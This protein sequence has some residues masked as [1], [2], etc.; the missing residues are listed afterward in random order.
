M[1]H[2]TLETPVSTSLWW[3]VAVAAVFPSSGGTLD[4]SPGL[5]VPM[6]MAGSTV[7][8][9]LGNTALVWCFEHCLKAE[10]EK[11]RRNLADL[12]NAFGFEFVLEKKCMGFLS[13]LEGRT[14]SVLLIAEW[15]EAKPI[16]EELGKR[17][18]ACNLSMCVVARTDKMYG[19]ACAWADKQCGS[20]EISVSLGFSL[21]KVEQL[22]A[23]HLDLHLNPRASSSQD[24]EMFA[25]CRSVSAVPVWPVQRLFL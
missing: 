8:W 21:L 12:A 22:V 14:G 23:R 4:E 20:T 3:S 18:I 7:A 6:D 2:K 17:H 1:E 15:R 5:L 25:F 19:R 9:E 10:H 24:L 11:E 13:W 16:M